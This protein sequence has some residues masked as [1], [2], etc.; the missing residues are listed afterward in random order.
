M[1]GVTRW[2]LQG[3]FDGAAL[4][5]Y[6]SV[7][8]MSFNGF[9]LAFK[10]KYVDGAWKDR[11]FRELSKACQKP[12][13]SVVQYTLRLEKLGGCFPG[14]EGQK[15]VLFRFLDGCKI[16]FYEPLQLH[17]PSTMQEAVEKA[18]IVEMSMLRKEL[19]TNMMQGPRGRGG[20]CGGRFGHAT[21][22]VPRN[23]VCYCCGK[24]GHMAAGCEEPCS[25]CGKKGHSEGRCTASG[26]RKLGFMGSRYGGK[27]PGQIVCYNC[28]LKGHRANQ[29]GGTN[30]VE[31]DADIN[32]VVHVCMD[33][34]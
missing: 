32:V 3:H 26:S 15:M 25:K 12:D 34:D 18:E 14:N 19:Y 8:C 17:A 31:E 33:P 10:A 2:V 16:E 24:P 27:L 7:H 11:A 5:W 30:L 6:S 23:V 1:N 13:T 29:C 21:L 4:V 20:F 28:G 22:T 9:V